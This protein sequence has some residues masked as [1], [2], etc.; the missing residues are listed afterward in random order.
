[1]SEAGGRGIPRFLRR[2]APGGICAAI[3][4]L[5]LAMLFPGSAGPS[6]RRFE[7]RLFTLDRGLL[8]VAGQETVAPMSIEGAKLPPML[9]LLSSEKG[10]PVLFFADVT[11]EVCL[12]KICEPVR[13]ELYWDLLGNY[14]GY[15]VV[16]GFPLLKYDHQ[17]FEPADYAKLHQVLSDR[18]SI[19]GKR[20][21]ASLLD[22]GASRKA[23]YSPGNGRQVDAVSGATAKEIAGSIV[24]GA[25]YS[26]HGIWNA[27]HG[28]VRAQMAAHLRTVF[29]REMASRFLSSD[30]PDYQTYALEES[31][32]A[33]VEENLPR[34]LTLFA[35]APAP[36][37]GCIL[38]RL[39][40]KAWGNPEV[41][42][43]LYG[44]FRNLDAGTR[45]ELIRNLELAGAEAAAILAD[46]IDAMTK[47][48]LIGYL[49]YLAGDPARLG[50]AIRNRLRELAA[51]EQ[52]AYG[53]VIGDF[54]R[55]L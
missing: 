24:Q 35:E 40:K 42:R 34:V 19:L 2:A 43:A 23:T 44:E 36:V 52:Y 4:V 17:P 26:C 1:M 48:Q 38:D 25:L 30:L 53:Y 3:G 10:Q 7:P 49:D 50:G 47:S 12:D 9:S 29:T 41:T 31:G 8:R 13:I 18:D 28:E 55:N 39:P 27:V 45:D 5:S 46:R 51:A 21:L 20:P 14:A 6:F 54:L 33:F 15:G 32:A 11:L 16:P 22:A 37:K